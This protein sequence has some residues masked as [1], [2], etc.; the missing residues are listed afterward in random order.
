MSVY[1]LAQFV[2]SW[3]EMGKVKQIKIKNRTY[4]FC[5]GIID[6]EEVNSNLLKIDKKSYKDIDIYYI[7]YIT[8]KK[9]DD[10]ENIYGVDPLYLIIHKVDGHIECNSVKHSSAKEKNKSKYLVFDSTDENE[11]TFKKYA[12]I[13][14]GIKNEIEAI[15]SGKKGEYGKDFMK[16]KVNTDDKLP[17]NKP[18]KLHLLTITVRFIFE[19]QVKFIHKFI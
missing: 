9:I 16:I 1:V 6:I 13:W 10:C 7:G 14:Y 5:N 4:Y 12:E 11:E 17:L 15:N 8:I 19:E 18:L 2:L 3:L